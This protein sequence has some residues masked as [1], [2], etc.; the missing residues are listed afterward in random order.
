MKAKTKADFFPILESISGTGYDIADMC[1]ETCSSPRY[2]EDYKIEQW[3]DIDIDR[4]K[5]I[6][7]E[8]TRLWER[9]D[10][11]LNLYGARKMRDSP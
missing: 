3:H 5:A 9:V 8:I 7:A 11:E 4:L 1:S 6:Q 2:D 10:W